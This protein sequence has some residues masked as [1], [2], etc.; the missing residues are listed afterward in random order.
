[1]GEATFTLQRT[2]RVKASITTSV[3][4]KK[5]SQRQHHPNPP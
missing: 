2:I 3:P 4:R 1:M 5:D